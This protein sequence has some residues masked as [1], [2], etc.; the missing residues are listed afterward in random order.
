MYRW[1]A[2][3]FRDRDPGSPSNIFSG[4]VALSSFWDPFKLVLAVAVV[5]FL[6]FFLSVF[7]YLA[8]RAKCLGALPLRLAAL[9]ALLCMLCTCVCV[10]GKKRN[11]SQKPTVIFLLF[12]L[13]RLVQNGKELGNRFTRHPSLSISLVFLSHCLCLNLVLQHRLVPLTYATETQGQRKRRRR[14]NAS[15]ILSQWER[16][17]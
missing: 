2:F 13:S 14:P 12:Q 4:L 8:P 5:A 11:K 7:G 1:W 6:S 16:M 10:C 9:S 3:Y 15:H 17:C